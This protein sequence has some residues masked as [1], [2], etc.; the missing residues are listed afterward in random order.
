LNENWR[1]GI[2]YDLHQVEKNRP[3]KLGGLE[4]ECD[5]GLVG[6]T[7]GDVVIHA[8]IDAILGAAGMPDIGERFPDTDPELKG[9]DSRELLATILGE[10]SVRGFQVNNVDITIIAERPK[11]SSSKLKISLLLAKMLN[12]EENRVSVKATTNEGF[13]AIGEGRAL[14]CQAVVSL[15]S[16]DARKNGT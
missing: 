14:A 2:G 4:I 16:G 9:R 8:L 6:H 1:I 7:D 12:I 15:K 5:F 11:L 3:L 13:D 10:V